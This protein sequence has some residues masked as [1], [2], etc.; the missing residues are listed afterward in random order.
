MAPRSWQTDSQAIDPVIKLPC[1][2]TA[3]AVT[4]TARSSAA[5]G[6]APAGSPRVAAV[7]WKHIRDGQGVQLD[8]VPQANRER[9]QSG[10]MGKE[11][12]FLLR[13]SPYS[14]HTRLSPRARRTTEKLRCLSSRRRA[15]RNFAECMLGR[16]PRKRPLHHV[17]KNGVEIRACPSDVWAETSPSASAPLL[18]RH[19]RACPRGEPRSDPVRAGPQRRMTGKSQTSNVTNKNDPRSLNSRVFIGN[20]NTAIVKKT[21]IEVIFAKYGKIVGC[22]VH[23]GFAFVQYMSE[24]NARAAVAGENARI[25]AGQP[26]GGCVLAECAVGL[27]L[28]PSRWFGSSTR[29]STVVL[30]AANATAAANSAFPSSP[31]VAAEML[32]APAVIR[33]AD[34]RLRDTA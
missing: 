27:P 32:S 24:R 26:L 33:E 12:G 1:T 34:A 2:G 13:A 7:R 11:L 21:D 6:R 5:Y 25:I 10:A 18:Q 4:E 23:K 31:C 19:C 15:P 9:Y 17:P 3:P 30:S 28:G 20:L 22:S 14:S 29:I 16:S 8:A